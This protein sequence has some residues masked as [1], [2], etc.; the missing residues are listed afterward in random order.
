MERTRYVSRE[1]LMKAESR[2]AEQSGIDAEGLRLLHRFLNMSFDAYVHGA[3]E[4]TMELYDPRVGTFMMDG[5]VSISTRQAFVEAICGKLH[6]VVV[7]VETTA[8]I[9][10]NAGVF[11]AAGDAKRAL[12]ARSAEPRGGSPIG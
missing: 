8:A 7:A 3:Y 5:H 11:Q 12:D 6:E 2:L 10:G 4:T 1:D 9:G